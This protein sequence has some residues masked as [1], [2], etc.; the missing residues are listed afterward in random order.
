MLPCTQSRTAHGDDH[1]FHIGL[2]QRDWR[3]HVPLNMFKNTQR[4]SQNSADNSHI[5]KQI[6]QENADSTT[7]LQEDKMLKSGTVLI[8][9]LA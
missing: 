5:L 2:L 6:N 9:L 1:H 8:A 3:D 7:T 4:A